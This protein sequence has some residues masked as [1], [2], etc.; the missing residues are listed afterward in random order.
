MSAATTD[1]G[2]APAGKRIYRPALADLVEA[3]YDSAKGCYWIKD[4]R[5]TW[6]QVSETSLKRLFRSKGVA[7]EVP[8]GKRVSPL[9][10]AVLDVQLEKNV[11]YAASLAGYSKGAYEILGKRVL[12]VDSPVLIE[13]K[14]GTWAT[15]DQVLAGLLVDEHFDQ[16]AFLFAWLKLAL[17][18][19]LA[20]ERRPG[21]ALAFAGPKDCGKS[22]L[23]KI[24]TELF[25]GRMA[26]PYAYMT[27]ATPFNSEMFRAEHLVIEDNAASTD[28]RARRS[29]GSLLKTITV[30]DCQPCYG[31][32][33]EAVSLTP[34][35]RLTISVNDEPEC[36]L[37]LPPI[38]ESI[39]D[40]LIL[41]KASSTPLPM[42]TGTLE[43]RRRFWETL[44]S[45]LPAFVHF[46]Q[47]WEIPAQLRGQR[48]GVTH[49]HHPD[50][51]RTLDDLAPE[52]QLLDLI[53]A[54]LF[55]GPLGDAWEGKAEVLEKL[56]TGNESGSSYA[57][58]RLLGFRAAC[59][60]YLGRLAKKHSPRV[61]R[62]VL[63]GH[64]IWTIEPPKPVRE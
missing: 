40:K 61:F 16:R 56:L 62:R 46:L 1:N 32:G 57:A 22:L 18:S 20:G 30:N 11:A 42:P 60:T 34:F 8:K 38:D 24:I 12:V 23:Q 9:D 4:A 52:T 55:S 26:S 64:S 17:E 36:L 39:E 49:F 6:M 5:G 2:A 29:F 28:I 19:L 3:Y 48:F 33:R 13:A 31:K 35:W 21:Q 50:L 51:L 53:D 47:G 44:V 43:E 10:L 14:A 54:E 15:L 27:G 41:L 58:R 45:E 63:D 25:G 59:G 7:A 37:V